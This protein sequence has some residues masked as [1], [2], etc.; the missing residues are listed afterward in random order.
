M[1]EQVLVEVNVHVVLSLRPLGGVERR[2][3][4]GGGGVGVG[5]RLRR[6]HAARRHRR[7]GGHAGRAAGGAQRV[8]AARAAPRDAPHQQLRQRRCNR[9]TT[10]IIT[11]SSI[12][13]RNSARTLRL[14][15]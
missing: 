2:G 1:I 14:G 10:P 4:V 12:A 11:L 9:P 6:P 3:R 7:A 5:A 13:A 15:I 8:P